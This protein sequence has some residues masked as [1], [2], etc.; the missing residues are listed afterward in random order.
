MNVTVTI[1][2]EELADFVDFVCEVEGYQAIV[3]DVDG[4]TE[5]PNPETREQFARR[6]FMNPLRK[7]FINW[8]TKKQLALLN[9]DSSINTSV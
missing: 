4:F 9:I 1:P 5:I 3:F 7:G 2:D 6:V 8:K